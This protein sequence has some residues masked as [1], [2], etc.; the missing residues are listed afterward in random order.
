MHASSLLNCLDSHVSSN[1]TY[2]LLLKFIAVK[3]FII[4]QTLAFDI[5]DVNMGQGK[6]VRWVAQFCEKADGVC[7]EQAKG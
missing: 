7:P 3:R 6:G 5:T 2:D 1:N 4:L